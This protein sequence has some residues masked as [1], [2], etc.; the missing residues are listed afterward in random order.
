MTRFVHF[1]IQ[2]STFAEVRM[3]MSC[4]QN[5]NFLAKQKL[6]Y[7]QDDILGRAT[8]YHLNEKLD[9]DNLTKTT[10]YHHSLT[11]LDT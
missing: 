3:G 7:F 5:V 10:Y 2:A 8:M 6:P 11:K 4:L 9:L 1:R